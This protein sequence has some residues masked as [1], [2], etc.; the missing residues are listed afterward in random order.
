MQILVVDQC[1]G[2]KRCPDWFNKL[3][4]DA[5]DAT[6][7]QELQGREQTPTYPARDLYTGRQQGYINSAVASLRDA[8]DEVD[9]LFI[10]AGFGVVDEETNLVPYEVTFK[11]YSPEDIDNRAEQLRIQSDLLDRL[12]NQYDIVFFALGSDY[13]RSFDLETVIDA[14][15]DNTLVV[16]FNQET[17]ASGRSNVVS[18]PAR[19]AE[20][21]EQGAIVVGLKGR[22]LQQFATHRTNGAA[23][24]SPED[25]VEYCTTEYTAQTGIGEFDDSGAG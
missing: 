14:I 3:D 13:Y 11:D 23:V 19:T 10:S 22:Y 1:S 8:G 15:P 21:A 6:S 7:L 2:S 24:E 12:E 4:A 25:V 20:A 5:I 18:I 17:L 16:L 9:R